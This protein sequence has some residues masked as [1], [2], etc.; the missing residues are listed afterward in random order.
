MG[1]WIWIEKFQTLIV[2]VIGVAGVIV[3]L[4]YNA[5][6]ARDQR[7][8]ERDHER[9]ALRVALIEELQI[10]RRSLKENSDKLREDPPNERGGAYVP[11]DPMDDAY[12][13]FVPKIGLLSQEEVS[14][15]MEAYLSLQTY[16]A[17]LFLLG[18]P[19]NTS[20]RHAKVPAENCTALA[21]LQEVMIGPIDEAI[22]ALT[23]ARGTS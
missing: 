20:P 14:K 1:M 3:T 11:T 19:V 13:S 8:D 15:V 12:R 2:G 6:V 21:D 18:V 16:N 4:L 17:K 23:R 22:E 7:R 10:N 5:K 9:E